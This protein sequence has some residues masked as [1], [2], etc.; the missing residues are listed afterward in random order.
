MTLPTFQ[1]S[2]DRIYPFTK[3]GI[4]RDHK[5]INLQY[6]L[7]GETEFKLTILCFF[8]LLKCL[9]MLNQVTTFHSN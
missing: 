5:N 9:E 6:N 3:D 1:G 8:L 4:K 2:V 7:R